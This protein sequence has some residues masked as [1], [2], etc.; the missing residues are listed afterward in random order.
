MSARPTTR[1]SRPA[2]DR[3]FQPAFVVE[4]VHLVRPAARGGACP[5]SSNLRVACGNGLLEGGVPCPS[6]FGL[7]VVPDFVVSHVIPSALRV[8]RFGRALFGS[9]VRPT[10]QRVTAK[11]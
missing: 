9:A 6:R 8:L 5:P 2:S 4:L 10:S 11:N 1:P 3:A 7:A